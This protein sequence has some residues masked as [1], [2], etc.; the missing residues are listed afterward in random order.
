MADDL[1]DRLEVATE[2][3][4]ENQGK[5]YVSRVPEL[6]EKLPEWEWDDE[7]RSANKCVLDGIE[8]EKGREIAE[9]YVTGLEIDAKIPITSMAQLSDQNNIPPV[10]RDG[11]TLIALSQKCNIMEISAAR[12]KES[13]FWDE[14]MNPEVMEKLVGE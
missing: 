12:L 2:Q 10:L 13:G 8:E 4:G 6:A 5:F 9:A 14:M 7:I 1:L 11:Q 3:I